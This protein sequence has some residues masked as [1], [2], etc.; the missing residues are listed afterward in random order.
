MLDD[1]SYKPYGRQFD[2]RVFYDW[3]DYSPGDSTTPAYGG[4][5]EVADVQLIAV[6]YF[7]KQGNYTEAG[8]YNDDEV[9]QLVEAQRAEIED[10][11]TQAANREG[12]GIANPLYSL[13]SASTPAD[14]TGAARMAASARSLSANEK[15]RKLG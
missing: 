14:A 13:R 9:W 15:E 6:R 11:C 12:V 1:E 5:A 2:I 10:A 3:V 7:D 8:E 4:F